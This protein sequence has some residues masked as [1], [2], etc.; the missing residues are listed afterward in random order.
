[1]KT[2]TV[3]L[4]L[5]ALV[6]SPVVAAE[7]ETPAGFRA[8]FNGKDL[9][10]WH[11]LNPHSVQKLEGEKREQNLAA[12]RAEFPKTWR[13]EQGELVNDGTGPYA[14]SDEEFGDIEL[15]L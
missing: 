10:G 3:F 4:A 5:L 2:N 15:R 7:P 12:Q 9:S 11:G 13:V 8:L 6:L 14:T 1:M